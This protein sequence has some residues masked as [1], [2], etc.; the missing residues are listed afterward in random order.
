MYVSITH[1]PDPKDVLEVSRMYQMLK[2]SPNFNFFKRRVTKLLSQTP[3]KTRALDYPP[4]LA[5]FGQ[6]HFGQGFWTVQKCPV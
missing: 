1:Q 5:H 2:D 6:L 4:G 3:T